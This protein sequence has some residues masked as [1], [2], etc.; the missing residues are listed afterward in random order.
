MID[1]FSYCLLFGHIAE[2]LELQPVTSNDVIGDDKWIEALI[3][4]DQSV[5]RFHG[6]SKVEKYLLV[7][8]NMVILPQSIN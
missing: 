2:G 3:I 8:S 6:K 4:A 1:Q 5:V 7:L